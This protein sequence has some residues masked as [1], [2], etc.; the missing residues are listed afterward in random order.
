MSEERLTER[1]GKTKEVVEG[2]EEDQKGKARCE[3]QRTGENGRRLRKMET[4]R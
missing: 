4:T 2:E 3:R 1:A